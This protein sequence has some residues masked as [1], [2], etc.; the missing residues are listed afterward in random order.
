MRERKITMKLSISRSLCAGLVLASLAAGQG[1]YEAHVAE[2]RAA[3]GAAAWPGGGMRDGLS[4]AGLILPGLRGGGVQS[5]GPFVTR[6]FTTADA[7]ADAR[8][9]LHLEARICDDVPAAREVLVAWLAHLSSPRLAPEDGAF[10]VELGEAGYVGPSGAANRA[11]SWVAFVRG[12]VAVRLLNVDLTETPQLDVLG[13]AKVIDAALTARPVL[14]PGALPGRAQIARLAPSATSV[15][16]G[17]A[18]RLEVEVVDPAGDAATLQ[19]RVGGSGQGYVEQREDGWHLFT[20]G[21]G[22]VDVT[23]VAIASTGT[24]T[25]RTVRLDVAAP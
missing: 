5:D 3:Y 21:P 20:T 4:V 13:A 10:G 24:I 9:L 25:E 14:A 17:A 18:P 16:A 6:D 11:V 8:P 19:W 2:V 15:V 1:T 7:P 22:E 12:N 23:L